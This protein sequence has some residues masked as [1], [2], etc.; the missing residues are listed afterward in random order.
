MSKLDE[1]KE[2]RRGIGIIFIGVGAYYGDLL[3][4]YPEFASKGEV[5]AFLSSGIIMAGIL[6]VIIGLSFYI[7]RVQK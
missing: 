3:K 2:I 1:L 4:K 5:I 6:L 7:W